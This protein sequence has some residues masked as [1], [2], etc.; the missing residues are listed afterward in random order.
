MKIYSW[1]LYG[2]GAVGHHL[3]FVVAVA[4]SVEEA[5]EKVLKGCSGWA[6]PPDLSQPP[7]ETAL[8]DALIEDEFIDS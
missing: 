4:A 5:R 7:T 1:K 3:S 8:E 2:K 6:E